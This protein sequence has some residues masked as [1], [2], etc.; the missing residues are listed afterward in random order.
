MLKNRIMLGATALT[1]AAVPFA[2]MALTAGPAGAAKAP[3]GITC[4]GGTGSG[5]VAK[6]SATINFTGCTPSTKTGG[7]GTTK[8]AEGA[9]SATVT[10]KNGKTTTFTETMGSGTA[11]PTTDAADELITGN[12]T[13]DTTKSTT[14]GAAVSAEFCVTL[15]SAGTNFK[16]AMAPGTKFKIAAS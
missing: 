3:K 13:A 14:V 15:N 12:V 6:L 16:L 5:K 1:A 7:T 2:G 10:W 11:C 4:S 9:S 8:G